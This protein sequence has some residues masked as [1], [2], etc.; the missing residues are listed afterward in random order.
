MIKYPEE[1]KM[2]GIESKLNRDKVVSMF[3]EIAYVLACPDCGETGFEIYLEDFNIESSVAKL[4][5][6]GCGS[7]VKRKVGARNEKT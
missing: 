3:E 6:L 1:I 4:R 2:G 7:V 5:C